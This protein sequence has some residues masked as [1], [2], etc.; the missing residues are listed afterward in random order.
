MIIIIIII[1]IIVIFVVCCSPFIM[2]LRKMRR[3]IRLRLQ[4]R[5]EL[6]GSLEYFIQ[7]TSGLGMSMYNNNTNNKMAI[8][9]KI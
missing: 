7:N 1:I 3:F 2:L 6:K 4:W 5:E 8:T 9:R